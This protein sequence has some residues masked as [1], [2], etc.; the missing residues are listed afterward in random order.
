MVS[1]GYFSLVSQNNEYTMQDF[2]MED[3]TECAQISL[4]L[5]VSL[6]HHLDQDWQI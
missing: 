3:I 6:S 5:R 1:G 4:V 2:G